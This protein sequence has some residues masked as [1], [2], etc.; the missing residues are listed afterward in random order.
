MHRERGADAG[1]A[2]DRDEPVALTHDAVD[3]RETETRPL[4]DVLRREERLEQ[5]RARL[6]RNADAVVD[7]AQPH[8]VARHRLH[9]RRDVDLR[10]T[11]T[12]DLESD[13]A[14]GRQRV[15]GVQHEIEDRLLDLRRID[16][17]DS[18][19]R[20]TARTSSVMSSRISRAS[21]FF[22]PATVA[23]EIHLLRHEDLFAAEREQLLRQRRRTLS[24]LLDLL[25]IGAIG[26][27]PRRGG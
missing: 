4:A 2:L 20:R 27:G 6:R 22:R 12:R 19:L 17:D 16:L 8:V 11:N 26:I 15:A 9:V 13:V 18:G 10:S 7:H 21:M 14:A 1:L 25:E 23:I 5:V 24:R 3:G